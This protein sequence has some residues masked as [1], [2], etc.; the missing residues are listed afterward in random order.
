MA[1]S[2]LPIRLDVGLKKRLTAKAGVQVVFEHTGSA[3]WKAS[4]ASLARFG[5]LVTCGATTGY[6]AALD[7][8]HVFMKHLTLLGSTMG[9]HG[10]MYQ[11]LRAAEQGRYKPVLDRVLPLAEARRAH[12]V[13]DERA[14]FGKVVLEP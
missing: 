6:E 14:Q 9:T 4:M 11:V 7:L 12:Q 1:N 2:V 8:R 10:D 3:T 5:R 13:L